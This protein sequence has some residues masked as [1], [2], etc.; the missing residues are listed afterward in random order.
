[1]TLTT[2]G[3]RGGRNELRYLEHVVARITLSAS[4]RGH[5]AIHLTSPQGTTSRLLQHRVYDNSRD[6]FKNW[7]FMTVFNWGEDPNGQWILEITR[8]GKVSNVSLEHWELMHYG[9]NEAPYANSSCHT[10]CMSGCSGP[11]ADQCYGCLHFKIPGVDENYT[12]VATCPAHLYPLFTKNGRDM[13]CSSTCGDGWYIAEDD[14]G[15]RTCRECS[16]GCTH[17]RSASLCLKCASGWNRLTAGRD[18][19][20]VTKCVRH[21]GKHYYL[22]ETDR[23]CLPC[24][25]ACSTC[26]GPTNSDCLSCQY[27]R[28]LYKRHCR[29]FEFCPKKLYNLGQSC[30]ANCTEVRGYY[31]DKTVMKCKPCIGTCASCFSDRFDACIECKQ[32]FYMLNGSCRYDCPRGYYKMKTSD[33]KICMPCDSKCTHAC[34]DQ[35]GSC[36]AK[37]LIS[38]QQVSS[39]CPFGMYLESTDV[40]RRPTCVKHCRTGFYANQATQ[41]CTKCQRGCIECDSQRDCTRCKPPYFLNGTHCLST[42]PRGYF[43]VKIN[44][45]RRCIPCAS[46]C[47]SCTSLQYCSSCKQS[48]VLA[49]GRCQSQCPS[50]FHARHSKP[51]GVSR[52]VACHHTCRGC[53]GLGSSRCTSCAN[54]FY[55]HSSRCSLHCPSGHYRNFGS[56]TCDRCHASCH[57]CIGSSPNRCTACRRGQTLRSH[58]CFQSCPSPLLRLSAVNASR[59]ICVRRCIRGTF[60]DRTARVCTP[61]HPFCSSCYGPDASNCI[62]CESFAVLEENRCVKNRTIAQ[63]DNQTVV[64]DKPIPNSIQQTFPQTPTLDQPTMPSPDQS[65]LGIVLALSGPTVLFLIVSVVLAV[66]LFQARRKLVKQRMMKKSQSNVDGEKLQPRVLGSAS[67]SNQ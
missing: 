52:C 32:N 59:L 62:T 23:I 58:Q 55:L 18:Y 45:F 31:S 63:I 29:N 11:G 8:K 19:R 51:P 4:N 36:R 53:S 56:R 30:V 5:V 41:R 28:V 25:K 12:C 26:N 13:L 49:G 14:D 9:T 3:C 37:S 67:Q 16:S 38:Y 47:S 10:E 57:A 48:L 24:S 54:H 20:E 6:G 50:G 1:M 65:V 61:C 33:G 64:Q 21:C 2:D 43:K 42:C 27:P 60:V 22:N 44:G 39:E 7:P 34:A 35:D 15:K 46:N 40:V 66:L 17:C